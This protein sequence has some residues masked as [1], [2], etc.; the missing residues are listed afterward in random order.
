[1]FFYCVRPFRTPLPTMETLLAD[2]VIEASVEERARILQCMQPPSAF[3]SDTNIDGGFVDYSG[4]T[5]LGVPNPMEFHVQAMEWEVREG[6]P[7]F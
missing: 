1:M 6:G 3:R 2:D 7:R 4:P 5:F